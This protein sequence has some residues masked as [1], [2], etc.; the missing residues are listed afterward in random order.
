[1]VGQG[2]AELSGIQVVV[3]IPM[4][5]LKSRKYLNDAADESY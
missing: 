2:G 1:M 5:L 4:R 3:E